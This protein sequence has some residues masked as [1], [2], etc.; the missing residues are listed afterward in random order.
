MSKYIMHNGTFR[1]VTDEE[2]MHWK[3]IKKEKKNGKWIYYYDVGEASYIDGNT[4]KKPSNI[5]GYT[6]LEDML[7][8][9]EQERARRA[10]AVYEQADRNSTNRSYSSRSAMEKEAKRVAKLGQAAIEA[11]KAYMKT[12]L[13]RLETAANTVKKA[14]KAVAKIFSNIAKWLSK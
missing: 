11:N 5:V 8:K 7:G 1:E 9:D 13:G 4:G 10:S 12:P 6:K 14:K 3:Y 2:L